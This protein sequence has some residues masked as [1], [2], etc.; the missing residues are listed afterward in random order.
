[1]KII[2]IPPAGK[3]A[4]I[5]DNFHLAA[6]TDSAGKIITIGTFDT[7]DDAETALVM[8]KEFATNNNAVAKLTME[9]YIAETF[10]NALAALNLTLADIAPYRKAFADV[11]SVS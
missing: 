8:F 2:D 9:E 7:L 3:I 11:F 5:A 10:Q 6:I 1:M 4:T